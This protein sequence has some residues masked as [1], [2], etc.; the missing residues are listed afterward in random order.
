MANKY[1]NKN[2]VG[3]LLMLFFT[4]F[5]LSVKCKGQQMINT[6]TFFISPSGNDTNNGSR[7]AP[8]KTINKLNSTKLHPGDT[9]CFE[10]GHIFDGHIL[11]GSSDA[12]MSD[13]PVT[14]TSYGDGKAIINGKNKT[15]LTVN[16]SSYINIS[17]LGFKGNGRKTGNT[18][19]GVII[20]GCSNIMIDSIEVSGFQKAG[21]LVYASTNVDINKVHAFDNGFAGISIAGEYRKRNCTNIHIAYCTAENNPGDPANFTNHSG[22]GILAGECKNV[23][24]EYCAATNNGWDMPRKGNGPV[25]IWCYEADSVIIQHCIS[26][27]NKTSPGAADGG[28][29]DLDGGV[30]NSII[31]YCLSYENEG[32]GYG[33]FQYDGAKNWYNNTIRFCISENDGAV[34]AAHAGIFI[35]NGSNDASQFKNCFVYNNTIYNSKGAVISYEQQSKNAGFLFYNN[36]FIGKGSL[37]TGKET[38]STYLGNNWYSI[39]DGFNIG[40]SRRFNAWVKATRKETYKGRIVGSNKDP[41]LTSPGNTS[42]RVPEKLNEFDKYKLP[43]D[44]PLRN[45][46]L[47]LKQLF[48][49]DTGNKTF[50]GIP[51][52]AN[53]I[54]AVF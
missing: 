43:V 22:N 49:I 38:N 26:Y 34:S 3:R 19:D 45:S 44:S 35:W 16:K 17:N 29:F 37:V 46:G 42:F 24:I 25:G 53:G 20:N 15:A 10:S 52:P 54:G 40:N 11:V 28:G 18:K 27:K 33:L 8:W 5:G 51:A 41:L 36:N 12:G 48:G 14:I 21:L 39:E 23:T 50:N 1:V 30:T 6:S 4:G 47:D 31:Q 32:S 13:H 2:S 9:V 7:L